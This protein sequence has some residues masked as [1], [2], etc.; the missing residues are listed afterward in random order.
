MRKKA[1]GPPEGPRKVPRCLGVRG[2]LLRALGGPQQAPISKA[3]RIWEPVEAS[4]RRAIKYLWPR[5][6]SRPRHPSRE[7]R[8]SGIP[9]G[10]LS[11]RGHVSHVPDRTPP[12]VGPPGGALF[13]V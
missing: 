4:A 8:G 7:A 12:P 3:S 10:V 6:P 11:S 2:R 13:P 1:P 9:P 5:P